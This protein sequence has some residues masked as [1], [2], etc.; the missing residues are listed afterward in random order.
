VAFQGRAI[1][2]GGDQG[3]TRGMDFQA[4]GSGSGMGVKLQGTAGLSQ[5]IGSVASLGGAWEPSVTYLFALV[6]AEMVVF[7]LIGRMLK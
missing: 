1:L 4:G 3:Y 2:P 7:H 6:V 5:G